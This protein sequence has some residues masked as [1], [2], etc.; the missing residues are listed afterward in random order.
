[1]KIATVAQDLF[2]Y[3]IIVAWEGRAKTLSHGPRAIRVK[4]G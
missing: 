4:Q 3:T 2:A 1:M